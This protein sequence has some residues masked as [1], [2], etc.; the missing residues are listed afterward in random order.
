MKNLQEIKSSKIKNLSDAIGKIGIEIH[1]SH[2]S[3]FLQKI[4]IF[5]F[6]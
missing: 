4:I 1:P 2:L 6:D 5:S 3:V